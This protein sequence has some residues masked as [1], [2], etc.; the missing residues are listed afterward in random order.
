MSISRQGKVYRQLNKKEVDMRRTIDYIVMGCVLG[1]ALVL[2]Y[3]ISCVNRMVEYKPTDIEE[4]RIQEQDVRLHREV[5][6]AI[7]QLRENHNIGEKTKNIR[8]FQLGRRLSA[9]NDNMIIWKMSVTQSSQDNK[10]Y[11]ITW[12]E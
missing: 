3:N 5:Q 4:F 2:V 10:M 12:E 9:T 8:A 1:I 6:Y 7:N 11:I